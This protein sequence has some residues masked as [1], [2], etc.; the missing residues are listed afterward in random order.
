METVKVLEQ[1]EFDFFRTLKVIESDKDLDEIFRDG[2]SNISY[3]LLSTLAKQGI[4]PAETIDRAKEIFERLILKNKKPLEKYLKVDLIKKE[5]KL[6][7]HYGK[8]RI[9]EDIKNSNSKSELDRAM[10]ALNDMRNIYAK[11]KARGIK[12][13]MN[14]THN[15]TKN[16]CRDI[17][18]TVRIMKNKVAH[19]LNK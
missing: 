14:G 12:D 15:L 8:K 19:I 3:T 4:I 18:A 16:D 9:L 5:K 7:K 2:K 13:K 6:P 10:L 17:I 11:L 1:P